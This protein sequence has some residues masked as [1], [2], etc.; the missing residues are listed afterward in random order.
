MRSAL[1]SGRIVQADHDLRLDQLDRAGSRQDVD[2]V[3]RD[4]RTTVPAAPPGAPSAPTWPQVAYGPP[5]GG[6]EVTSATT[7]G[8]RRTLGVVVGLIVLL[9]V[10]LPI[11]GAAIAFFASR[12]SMPTFDDLGPTDETTYLPGQAPGESGVNMFTEEGFGDLGA[13][14]EDE[15]G[16]RFVYRAT[17]YP[18]YAVLSVPT[19]TGQRYENWY[20][21]GSTLER[22]DFKSTSDDDQFDLTL[23]DPRM[24]IDL[25]DQ[26][27]AKVDD[28]EVWY[29][30]LADYA[31]SELQVTVSASNEYGENAVLVASLDGTITYDSTQ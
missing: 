11:A 9:G 17:M 20:W 21:D 23:L 7:S 5:P 14:L 26:V 4:L 18:R 6:V 16:Q 22:Q 28:P 19:G 24:I 30:T 3:V 10:V 13:A 29:A 2:L 31:S 1:A 12:D 27:R 25:V 15:T 8:P